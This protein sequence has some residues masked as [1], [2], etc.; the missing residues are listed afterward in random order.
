MRNLKSILYVALFT[1]VFTSCDKDKENPI[2]APVVSKQV[3]NLYAPVK[4]D[5]TKNPP[6]SSGEFVRFSFS[7]GTKVTGDN[8]DIAFRGT[9]IIVNGGTAIGL[10]SEPKRTGKA[11]LALELNTFA[12]VT[13]APADASFKQD[14]PKAY[15]LPTGSNKGWYS[16]NR[17][18]HTINPIAGKVIVVKTH[19]GHYAKMEILSYYK[20]N[21][22]SKIENARYYT[23]N[24]VYNP[25]KGGKSLK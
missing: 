18:T 21:D 25:N 7:E 6:V 17:T 11:A 16:Y 13:N 12:N 8:W 24:Y 22:Q 1:L 23:F 20:D 4:T 10:T 14:A 15:A 19:N 3:K 5:Y 9:S 2:S